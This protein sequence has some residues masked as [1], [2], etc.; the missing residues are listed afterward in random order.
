M[1][2]SKKFKY[3]NKNK[4]LVLFKIFCFFLIFFYNIYINQDNQIKTNNKI[5]EI[6][7]SNFSTNYHHLK[8]HL[9]YNKNFYKFI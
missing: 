9:K 3:N 7:N 6:S 2:F 5:L 8:Y 4:V 1:G